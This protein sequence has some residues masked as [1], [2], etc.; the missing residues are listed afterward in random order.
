MTKEIWLGPIRGRSRGQL[1]QRCSALLQDTGIRGDDRCAE[2]L[3]LPASRPLLDFVTDQLLEV[4]SAVWGSLPVHLFNGFVNRVLSTAIDSIT[5][6]PLA[7]RIPIDREELPLKRSLIA[8]LIKSLARDG[9]ISTLDPLVG[10]DGC[11]NSIAHIIGEIQRAAKNPS[12]FEA[13]LTARSPDLFD[14]ARLL[15]PSIRQSDFDREVCIIYKAYRDV[16]DRAALTEEDTD[17]LLALSVLRGAMDGSPVTCPWLGWGLAPG[18]ERVRLLVL[19]GFFDFTP[20][21]GEMLRLL[22]D[23][24][25]DVVISLNHDEANPEVFRAFDHTIE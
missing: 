8:R 2:F 14:G 12:E 9:R 25:D 19:D 16:L 22:I 21:Q 18:A 24:I 10:T 3:Y 17:Q 11:I 7:P 4:S 5:G 1:I 6:K 13:V 23:R 15:F 20:I